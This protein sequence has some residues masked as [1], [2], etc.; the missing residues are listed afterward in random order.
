[1]VLRTIHTLIRIRAY[2]AQRLKSRV[3]AQIP[4]LI[5]ALPNRSLTQKFHKNFDL[6]ANLAQRPAISTE[7]VVTDVITGGKHKGNGER[8]L[9]KQNGLEG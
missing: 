8:A 6:L 2:A 4:G 1:M 3:V 5:V 7:W 9:S